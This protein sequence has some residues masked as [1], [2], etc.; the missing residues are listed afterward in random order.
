MESQPQS[1]APV[2]PREDPR[3]RDTSLSPA[4]RAAALIPLLTLEEKVAQLAGVWVGASASGQ[5]V[6]PHQADMVDGQPFDEVIRH[7]LGQLTR[8]FG[9]AP[10]DPV[11]GARSL[12]AAQA[13][14][15]ASSRLGIPAQ[16]HEECLT[17]FCTWQAT[18]YPAPLSWGAAF[19]PDARRGNGGADRAVHAGGRRA[20]GPCPG[21]GR[22]LRLPVGP[23]R[24]DD[25]RGSLPG[26]HRGRGVRAR[27][28]RGRHRRDAEALRRVLRVARRPQPRPGRDGPS[29]PGGRRAAAVRDG[30]A[31]WPPSVGDELLRGNRRRACRRRREPADR[32]AA[33]A[34]GVRGH[35][36]RRLLRDPLPLRPAR[37]R[38]RP[39]RGGGDGAAGGHRRRTAHDRN[40]WRDAG[41]RGALRRGRRGAG[42]PGRG[43][44][45]GAEG[46]ARP[47]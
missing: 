18:V 15:A 17:G 2:T 27:A 20:P 42:R 43:P 16:V 1:S 38:G 25:R 35:G 4:E 36:G 8:P 23:Y 12:A 46:R 29:P 11:A 28:R 6:A 19:D 7:G 37:R 47:A 14:I 40:V 10:V 30:T 39:G 32:P 34:V 44:R 9:T 24:G 26:R 41:R 21:H 3:W 45:A 22:D 33:R 13:R 31:A 5:G